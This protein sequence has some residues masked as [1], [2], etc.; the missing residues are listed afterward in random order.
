MCGMT[1]LIKVLL[2]HLVARNSRQ[3]LSDIFRLFALLCCF[4]AKTE[5]GFEACEAQKWQLG[6]K[7]WN[8]PLEQK[9]ANFTLRRISR[10]EKIRTMTSKLLLTYPYTIEM[11]W[12]F[13]FAD[14]LLKWCLQNLSNWWTAC[15][16][17]P[18]KQVKKLQ[19]FGWKLVF[20]EH[21][22]SNL[23]RGGRYLRIE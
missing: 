11:H 5:V 16:R 7:L 22:Q 15:I 3:R 13:N 1:T 18:L 17:P 20:S 10:C 8:L 21:K 4:W 2:M 14:K 9:I 12:C 19:C 23:P 6:Y